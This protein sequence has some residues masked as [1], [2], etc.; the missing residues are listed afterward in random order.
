MDPFRSVL[1]V[2]RSTLLS[3]IAWIEKQ[4]GAVSCG[5]GSR[6]WKKTRERKKERNYGEEMVYPIAK[7]L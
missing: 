4:E 5:N 7:I 6:F 1:S 2:R 3:Y